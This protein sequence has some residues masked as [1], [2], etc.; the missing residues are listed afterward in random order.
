MKLFLSIAMVCTLALSAAGCSASKSAAMSE[1]DIVTAGQI[2]EMLAKHLYKVDFSRAYPASA[3]SFALTSP[4]FISVIGDRV[5]SFLPYYGRSYSAVYGGGEG[6][7]FEAPVSKYAETVKRNGAREI[8]F[9][10]RS[11]EDNYDFI[12]TVFPMG[13]CDLT[14]SPKR[15]QVISFTGNIDLDPEFEAVRVE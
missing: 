7:R 3:P 6:L 8:T 12:L 10:A 13:R 9:T 4:Y 2:D 14:I 5:E 1:A 11:E 15:K